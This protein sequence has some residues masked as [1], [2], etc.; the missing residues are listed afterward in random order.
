ML[1][2]QD[3]TRRVGGFFNPSVC[4]DDDSDEQRFASFMGPKLSAG[5]GWRINREDNSLAMQVT[6]A[7]IMTFGNTGGLQIPSYTTAELTSA[8]HAV[9][10]T[11]KFLNKIV[12]NSTTGIVMRAN[13]STATATWKDF[14]NGSTITPV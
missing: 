10:T 14:M 1:L 4:I 13:G 12:M 2:F 9:N 6:S 5:Q 8:T 11:G 3:G 7:G